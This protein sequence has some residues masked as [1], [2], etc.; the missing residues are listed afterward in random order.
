MRSSSSVKSTRERRTF[1]WNW[2]PERCDASFA[3]IAG[4]TNGP[5]SSNTTIGIASH[6]TPMAT[7]PATISAVTRMKIGRDFSVTGGHYKPRGRATKPRRRLLYPER[8]ENHGRSA[9][10]AAAL[11]A[12]IVGLAIFFLNPPKLDGAEDMLK[13]GLGALALI[14]VTAWLTVVLTGRQ[15]MSEEEF[16]RVVA[17]AEALARSPGR[18]QEATEFELLLAEAIDE[19]PEEFQKVLE[20]VPVVVS[21]RGREV[22][23]YGRYYGDTIARDNFEDRIVIYQ[24]TLERDFGSDP[25]LL[26]AQVVQTLRHELAHH[27]GWDEPGVRSL[28]L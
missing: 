8:M 19:L 15:D 13:L 1:F 21:P 7:Q 16:D 6:Q 23:A 20:D 9:L 27:L 4:V 25:D 5:G 11:T 22:R 12:A 18:A 3:R 14:L 24:D 26:R 2:A 10:R 17:R 28:G